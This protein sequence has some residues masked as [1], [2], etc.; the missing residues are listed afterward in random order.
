MLSRTS[1]TASRLIRRLAVR[2]VSTEAV[3][4]ATVKLNFNL[5]HEKIYDGASVA[6]VIIPGM[7]VCTTL[8]CI[9]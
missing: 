3:A 6:S 5:P 8:F 4:A 9:L 2:S 7:Y 1:N